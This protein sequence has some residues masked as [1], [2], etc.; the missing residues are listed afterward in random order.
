VNFGFSNTLFSVLLTAG[1]HSA[2][3]NCLVIDVSIMSDPLVQRFLELVVSS[4]YH[5]RFRWNEQ[6]VLSMLWQVFVPDEQIGKLPFQHWWH[7]NKQW[8]C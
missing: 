7:P 5:Y 3:G 6:A 1:M 4:Q 2:G 8:M